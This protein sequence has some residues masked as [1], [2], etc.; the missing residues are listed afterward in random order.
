MRRRPGHAAERRARRL[1]N[2][3]AL[4]EVAELADVAGPIV[5]CHFGERVLAEEALFF[6]HAELLEERA[7]EEK[8][9]VEALA[10]RRHAGADDGDA[11]VEVL[12]EATLVDLALEVAVRRR[13]DAD[14]HAPRA[15]L[16]DAPNLLRLE[17]AEQLGLEIERQFAELVEEHGAAVG[18][19]EGAHAVAIGAGERAAD[20]TEEL[21]LDQRR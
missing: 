20:M 12:A 13:D 7:D 14:V 9:V 8:H 18:R 4:D 2:D 17:G 15:G 1:Q 11:E 3:A 16:T 19:F 5:L 10:E 21:A 6:G